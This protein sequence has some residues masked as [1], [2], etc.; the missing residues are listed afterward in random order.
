MAIV[1]LQNTEQAVDI[2]RDSRED[3]ELLTLVRE[4]G[5]SEA[6]G[7]LWKRHRKAAFTQ[8]RRLAN[9][10][11]EDIV[12]EA[13]AAIW[14]QLQNGGGPKDYFRAYVLTVVRNIA[15]RWYRDRQRTITSDEFE[16][17]HVPGGDALFAAD[18]ERR[19]M[20]AAF[21]A[22]PE[23]WQE[24]LWLL[25]SEQHPRK[26][27]AERLDIAPN[28]VSVLLRR[29]KEGLRVEWLRQ[30]L[31]SASSGLRHPEIV[32]M[33]P[34]YALGTLSRNQRRSVKEHLAGCQECLEFERTIHRELPRSKAAVKGAGGIVLGLTG[35]GLAGS[36]DV[37]QP[38]S[39]Q[40]AEL[41]GMSQQ[42]GVLA[43]LGQR[44]V[45]FGAL[46][47]TATLAPLFGAAFV[48]SAVV[49]TFMIAGSD[50]SDAA[51]SAS[52]TAP[53]AGAMV[54]TTRPDVAQDDDEGA[55]DE[56]PQDA[57]SSQSDASQS[58]GSGDS[59]SGGSGGSSGGEVDGD[60]GTEDPPQE[61]PAP[62]TMTSSGTSGA[63]APVLSG[64]AKAGTQ[65]SIAISGYRSYAVPV[66]ENGT[67]STDVAVMPLGIG[68]Y[69]AVAT[70]FDGATQTTQFSLTRPQQV[71][72]GNGRVAVTGG[73]PGAQMCFRL[74]GDAYQRVVLDGAGNGQASLSSASLYRYCDG[75]R[76]GPAV[77]F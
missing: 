29:A 1:D 34:R 44:I 50:V 18:D 62:F 17:D 5:D 71:S 24:V 11:A 69:T 26:V 63:I 13:F 67:W 59:Q 74:S 3:V 54:E 14:E 31:P 12:A 43:Q 66:A 70:S 28:A 65:V 55:L 76:F 20:M 41:A 10:D 22:L 19:M 35:A 30:M 45:E 33:L 9:G 57:E 75:S 32:G 77:N 51:D 61:P 6:F 7:E 36:M 58:S 21:S 39:A 16:G 68:V 47:K 64:I 56:A 23:R 53:V 46:T 42:G 40:A 73:V 48:T 15:S 8:A 37:L 25:E 38:A 2:E 4:D 60:T 72:V 52:A 27:V 49:A